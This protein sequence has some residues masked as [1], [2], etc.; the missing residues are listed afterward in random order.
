M[1]RLE[2]AAVALRRA[3]SLDPDFARAHLKLATI[4]EA[5]GEP[6]AARAPYPA[7]LRLAPSEHWAYAR[8]AATTRRQWSMSAANRVRGV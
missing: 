6:D 7:G 4:F 1:G 2:E 8:L 5:L 3:I